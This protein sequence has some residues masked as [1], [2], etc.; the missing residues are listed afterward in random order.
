MKE[1]TVVFLISG[2]KLHGKDTFFKVGREI[3]NWER[4]AFADK[5]KEIGKGLFDLTEDQIDGRLKETEDERYPNKYDAKEKL[6]K[7]DIDSRLLMREDV[8]VKSASKYVKNE[9]YKPFLSPRR[10]FQIIGKEMRKLYSDVWVNYVFNTKVPELLKSGAKSVAIT[11]VRFPNEIEF[12]EKWAKQDS[13]RIIIKVR[14]VRPEIEEDETSLDE[15]ETSLD[16]YKDW[17]FIINNVGTLED[18]REKA[19]TMSNKLPEFLSLKSKT[20][21]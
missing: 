8:V 21:I 13:D 18:L 20:I 14:V 9:I 3:F 19:K 17:D 15:S 10:L 2:K 5:I 6:V 16:S 1:K 11:D 12:A 4:T 7:I